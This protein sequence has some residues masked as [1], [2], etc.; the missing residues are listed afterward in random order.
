[1]RGNSGQYMMLSKLSALRGA[2]FAIGDAAWPTAWPKGPLPSR[3][4]T[5]CLGRL[6]GAHGR[7]PGL[8]HGFRRRAAPQPLRPQ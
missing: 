1:M 2:Y 3:A 8:L 6:G 5:C 4:S 7:G